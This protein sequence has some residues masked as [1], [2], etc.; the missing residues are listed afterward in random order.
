MFCQYCGNELPED[1]QFCNKCGKPVSKTMIDSECEEITNE[2][3]EELVTQKFTSQETDSQEYNPVSKSSR[4]V[5][6]PK[7]SKTQQTP[8]SYYHGNYCGGRYWHR[9]HRK[10]H[11]K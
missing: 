3:H 6:T 9:F 7:K 2:N 11:R 10:I 5:K 1:A 4:T 8:V